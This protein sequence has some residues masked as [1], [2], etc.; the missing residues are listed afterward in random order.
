[1]DNSRLNRDIVPTV[2]STVSLRSGS[3]GP[4]VGMSGGPV[5]QCS[6]AVGWTVPGCAW[7]LVTWTVCA[8]PERSSVSAHEKATQLWMKNDMCGFPGGPVVGKYETNTHL[9]RM[10]TV[11]TVRSSS[12]LEWIMIQQMWSF[13]TP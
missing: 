8:T 10:P 6:A 4:V 9:W 3:S 11:G 5:V 1:M 13:V 7:V 12:R 2:R